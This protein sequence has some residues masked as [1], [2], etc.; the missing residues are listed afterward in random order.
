[1]HNTV[2]YRDM[3]MSN[4]PNQLAGQNF[5]KAEHFE[6][7]KWLMRTIQCCFFSLPNKSIVTEPLLIVIKELLMLLR[8][9]KSI[10]S[11]LVK[12]SGSMTLEGLI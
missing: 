5:V 10:R 7:M 6:R 11:C 9:S 8:G 2:F 3:Y 4:D 1:M 12:D